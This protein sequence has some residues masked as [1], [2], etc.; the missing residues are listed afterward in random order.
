MMGRI[1]AKEPPRS[2]SRRRNSPSVSAQIIQR[3]AQLL[4][5]GQIRAGGCRAQRCCTETWAPTYLPILTQR[6][7]GVAQGPVSPAGLR[8]STAEHR[9]RDAPANNTAAQTYRPSDPTF[10]PVPSQRNKSLLKTVI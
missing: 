7:R 8:P 1:L 3:R 10:T 2:A 6:P 5:G 9:L 4:P